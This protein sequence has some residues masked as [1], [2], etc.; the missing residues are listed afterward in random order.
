MESHDHTHPKGI[1]H[2]KI[3]KQA[4]EQRDLML[5]YLGN[6]ISLLDT[7][8]NDSTLDSIDYPD[9]EHRLKISTILI[10]S[11]SKWRKRRSI[12]KT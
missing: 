6:K 5:Y 7:Q 2:M 3:K 11:L 12:T 1:R 9:F 4:H 8:T 10:S